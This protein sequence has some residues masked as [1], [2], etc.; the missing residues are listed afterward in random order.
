MGVEGMCDAVKDTDQGITGTR[1]AQLQDVVLLASPHEAHWSCSV[2][3]FL[4][5]P[6]TVLGF[7][8]V[9]QPA[10]NPVPDKPHV[11]DFQTSEQQTKGQKLPW[12]RGADQL[13]PPL[14]TAKKPRSEWPKQP[15]K[16]KN[17]QKD[18][19]VN[20]S[21]HFS[22]SDLTEPTQI[23][24]RELQPTPARATVDNRSQT[25]PNV[26]LSR[27]TTTTLASFR[28]QGEPLQ[29]TLKSFSLPDA[30]QAPERNNENAF[31]HHDT[32]QCTF[33]HDIP[34]YGC[35]PSLEDTVD[36]SVTKDTRTDKPGEMN[37]NASFEATCEETLEDHAVAESDD[38][39]PIDEQD[40]Q[41]LFQLPTTEEGFEPPSSLQMP[42][43]DD[44]QTNGIYDPHLLHS[45]PSSSRSLRSIQVE[46]IT[47]PVGNRTTIDNY[48][49]SQS[50]SS[51]FLGRSS[52]CLNTDNNN[53]LYSDT[54]EENENLLDDVDSDFFDL[55]AAYPESE[56][57]PPVAPPKAALDI[58]L[59]K[60][61]W[62]PST[63]YKPT[64][65][66]PTSELALPSSPMAGSQRLPLAEIPAQLKPPPPP[67]PHLLSFDSAGNA[68][69]FA[70]PTFP[71]LVLDRSPILGVSS[72]SFLRTCFRIGEAL[73][74]A[75]QALHTNAHPLIELYARVTYSRRIGVEQFIQFAD[76]FRSE[77]PPFLSGSF[78][79]WKG[80]DLWDNDS[81]AFL[82]D[83]GKG[84]IA[85]CVGRMK[86]D[87]TG[88]GWKMMVLSI[89]K[90]DWEDV[91]YVKGI[92]CS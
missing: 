58:E 53:E 65:S 81:K 62:N 29:R 46:G 22:A 69:P 72:S 91:G 35:S 57:K 15:K 54:N 47:F 6:P 10:A 68:L 27:T 50:H 33:S 67:A 52:P 20:L 25:A 23:S 3:D 14:T 13:T 19:L 34:D 55:E 56:E 9:S 83:T 5:R 40:A 88:R 4:D 30:G 42:F 64:K 85:R 63:M 45:R 16:I 43:D 70:R 44:S 11:Q 12:K 37:S 71:S 92:V 38:E 59:P 77:K 39:F 84:K 90:A 26:G 41:C 87:E 60:L 18:T 78:V 32:G 1:R 76:L 61:Q 48:R 89:W 66:L 79:G 74:V 75:T 73:N 51:P 36:N 24:R 86:R 31:R 28:Y 82:G 7:T 2:H 49:F 80:V 17:K 21:F 8:P